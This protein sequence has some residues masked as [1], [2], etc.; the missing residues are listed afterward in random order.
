MESIDSE[1][2]VDSHPWKWE[3]GGYITHQGKNH[4]SVQP[5]VIHPIQSQSFKMNG[6]CISYF[7]IASL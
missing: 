1:L 5:E 3:V 7:V 2:N 6:R 4:P